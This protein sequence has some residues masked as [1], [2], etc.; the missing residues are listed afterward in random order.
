[1]QAEDEQNRDDIN[2]DKNKNEEQFS[3]D[4][5]KTQTQREFNRTFSIVVDGVVLD[6]ELKLDVDGPEETPFEAPD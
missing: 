3:A 4:I 5:D 1:M 6:E 2:L